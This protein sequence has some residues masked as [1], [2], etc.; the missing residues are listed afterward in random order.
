MLVYADLNDDLNDWGKVFSLVKRVVLQKSL[1]KIQN[2]M[3]QYEMLIAKTN[4]NIEQH[5]HILYIINSLLIT[6]DTT[7]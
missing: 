2:V 3:R 4:M 5:E 1:K 7:Y 6:F